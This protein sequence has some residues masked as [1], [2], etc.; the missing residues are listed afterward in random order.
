METDKMAY[1]FHSVPDRANTGSLKWDK[2]RGRDVLPFWVADMDFRSP[3]EVIEALHQRADH[4]IFGYT[5]PYAEVEDAVLNDLRDRHGVHAERD[6]LIW[7]PGL[8]P[9][10]NTAARAFAGDGEEILT[11][12]P[13]YPP[14]LSAPG[15]Q[16]R[17]LKAAALCQENGR[18]TFDFDALEAAVTP[19]TRAFYLCNPH[20]PVGRVYDEEELEAVFAFCQKHRLALV[21]DEIHCDLVL[22][23]SRKHICALRLAE[24]FDVDLVTMF[25]PS[26]TYN[27]PGLACS[28]IVIPDSRV[29]SRFKLASRGMITEVNCFGYT[30]C[31]VAMS[32]CEGWRRE[33]IGVLQSNFRRLSEFVADELPLIEL[34]RLEAT[35]LAWLDVRKLGLENPPAHFESHG[36]GLSDG[37][38]FGLSGWLRFNFGCPPALLEEGLKRFKSGYAAAVSSE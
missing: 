1:D 2:Y 32:K 16:G 19:A 37:A 22:D 18:W 23:D 8:V 4:G 24:R 6:W 28:Y 34:T 38:F 25:A 3:P 9:A 36:I 11:C 21:S 35:Y 10:L 29:R 15:F 31:A 27:L 30:G 20:N 12:T 5:S 17:Q 33:L 7:M 14:F 26:K 13:V